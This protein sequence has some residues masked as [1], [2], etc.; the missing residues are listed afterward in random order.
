MPSATTGFWTPVALSRDLPAGTVMPARTAAGSIALWRSAS[1]RISASADRCPHRGMRLSHGF[2]RGEA[3]SCIYHGW[4]YGQAGN[5]LR[6]PAHPGLAPPETIRVATHDVE[7]ADNVIWVAVGTPAAK[8]PRLE[9]LI[10][11]RSLTALAGI[12]AIEA[13]AGAK[14]SPEGLLE[15]NATSGT[16]CLLLSAQE[17][18]Q[19]LIH[20]L[21]KPDTGPAAGIGASRAAESLRRRAED[22]QRKEIGQ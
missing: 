1:G 12:A 8:P 14:A 22:L 20:V 4:S 21:L 17:D 19:T 18:G 7:E 5:C 15:F 16:V 13:A 2:V 6:I 11:L 9:G 10:P 3:L